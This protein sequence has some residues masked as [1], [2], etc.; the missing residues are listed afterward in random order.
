MDRVPEPQL[1][2][3]PAQT[4]AYAEADFSEA[5]DLF[6]HHMFRHHLPDHASII[7]LGCGPAHIAIRLASRC[8]HWHVTALDGGANMLKLARR[9]IDQA[10]L[11]DRIELKL[12]VLPDVAGLVAHD[13]VI[14]NSLLHHLPDPQVLWRSVRALLIPGGR[15]QVMDLL[16][17]ADAAEVAKL[18][19]RYAAGEPQVLKDDFRN[20]LFAAYT[21][22]E[23][24]QQLADAA[25]GLRVEQVSDRHWL[26]T[27]CP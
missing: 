2:D 3:S 4:A 22:D 14:S 13:A 25:M 10:R 7:D 1:M 16:R 11:S 20:S 6:V 21:L 8:P 23:I 17:P 26:A 18:V 5:N 9:A 27:G 24:K 15:V 12:K 19:D